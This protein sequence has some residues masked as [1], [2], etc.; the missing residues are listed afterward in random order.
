[1][2]HTLAKEYGWS[3]SQ[4]DE[5]YPAEATVYLKFI[6]FDRKD[7]LIQARIDYQKNLLDT[8]LVQHTGEPEGLFKSIISTLETLQNLKNSVSDAAEGLEDNDDDL[9]D[10]AKLNEL[11][12]FKKSQG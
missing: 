8:L 3:K 2:I 9:P 11:K 7:K 10:F 5:V 1:M 6:A 12:Q 4:F